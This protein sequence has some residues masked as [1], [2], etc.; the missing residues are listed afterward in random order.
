MKNYKSLL[1][2]VFLSIFTISVNAEVLIPSDEDKESLII[3]LVKH[4][5]VDN[6][7]FTRDIDNNLAFEK[8]SYGLNDGVISS[9]ACLLIDLLGTD[10]YDYLEPYYDENSANLYLVESIYNAY[11]IQNLAKI[12]SEQSE[13]SII[14][15]ASSQGLELKVETYCKNSKSGY[16]SQIGLTDIFLIPSYIYNLIKGYEQ[17]P[18]PAYYYQLMTSLT[19]NDVLISWTFDEMMTLSNNYIEV[20]AEEEKGENEFQEIIANLAEQKSKDFMGSLFLSLNDYGSPKFCTLNYSGDDAVAAIGYRLLGDEMIPNSALIDYYNKNEL[21]LNHNENDNYFDN[22]FDDISEA[23]SSIKPKLANNEDYCNIFVDYPENLLRLKNALERDLGG[24]RVLGN[25]FDKSTTDK[26][27]ALGQGFDDYQ[28]YSFANQINAS[29]REINS[30]ESYQIVNLSEFNNVQDE[31]VNIGYS[32]DT[33]LSI[34]L[35]Y[36]DDLSKAQQKNMDVNEYR[37]ARLKEEQRLAQIAREEEAERQAA[38][39]REYP[40]TATLTCGMG[41]GDHINIVACFVGSGSYGVDTE[42]E[43]TNGQNYQMYKPYNLTQ[44]GSEYYSGFEIDLR[45]SFTIKAQNSSE[46]LVLSLK[47]VDNATGTTL[48]QDSAAE[49]GVIYVSN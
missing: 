14:D 30:L 40:Y 26:Q 2:I 1:L 7:I 23:F 3:Y 36:L 38:F 28:Q 46:N 17:N 41:G 37:D 34:V 49:Y 43:I 39:A 13:Q 21:T 5:K 11:G 10:G 44:A 42:L 32:S 47:I 22:T 48:F 12:L 25:L 19:E 20:L 4:P 31:I 27:Y 29:Y 18:N 45:D 15:F 6:S 33:N 16:R 9:S 24:Q 8:N 35:T